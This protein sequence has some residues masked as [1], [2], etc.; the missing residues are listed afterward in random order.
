MAKI[1]TVRLQTYQL[2]K[3]I[4][5]LGE[6]EELEQAFRHLLTCQF[7]VDAHL[8]YMDYNAVKESF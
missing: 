7:F 3:L 8:S 6:S 4:D 5:D 1:R 2:Q